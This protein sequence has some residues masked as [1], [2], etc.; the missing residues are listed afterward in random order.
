MVR[1]TNADG[2]VQPPAAPWNAKGYGNNAMP[3]VRFVVA[4]LSSEALLP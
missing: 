2:D 4:L 3:R 1:A